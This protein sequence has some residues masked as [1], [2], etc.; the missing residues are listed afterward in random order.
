MLSNRLFRLSLFSLLFVF[1]AAAGKPAMAADEEKTSDFIN[2]LATSTLDS[3]TEPTL[4]DAVRQAR[5]RVLFRKN[6]D[7]PIIARFV[8]GRYW[9]Q[10]TGAQ[11]AKF[12]ALLEDYIVLSYSGRF[13]DYG[14]E[15]F[16]IND[17]RA[18]GNKDT[19]VYT[20]IVR[21]KASPVRIDW[22]VRQPNNHMKVIDVVIEGL[23]MSLTHRNEFA[24]VIQRTG[25]G[26][27]GLIEL[28]RKKTAGMNRE[29]ST[30]S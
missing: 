16:E 26:V 13:K 23:S 7:L 1:L 18:D 27:D 4:E 24:A 19:I 17:V 6:F 22:R 11:Q 10:A 2:A 29:G 9:K 5:F 21:K 8:L 28:L 12:K 14:G 30:G 15:A 3:L 25:S 20:R